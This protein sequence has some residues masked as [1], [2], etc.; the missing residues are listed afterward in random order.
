MLMVDGKSANVQGNRAVILDREKVLVGSR[1]SC[2][3]DDERKRKA[4]AR[5]WFDYHR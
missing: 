5:D 4:R 1:P 2:A 3:D